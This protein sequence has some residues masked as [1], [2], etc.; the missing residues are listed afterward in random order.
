M[1]MVR[2]SMARE[3]TP[4]SCRNRWARLPLRLIYRW[5]QDHHARRRDQGA[6]ANPVAA[7][8]FDPV[9]IDRAGAG[10]DRGA[11]DRAAAAIKLARDIGHGLGRD[12]ARPGLPYAAQRAGMGDF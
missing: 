4:R 6:I 2:N 12:D 8:A 5:E 3:F 7:D 9:A 10:A 1:A 11:G